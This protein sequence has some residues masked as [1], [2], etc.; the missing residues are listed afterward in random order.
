M[1]DHTHIHTQSTAHHM[2]LFFKIKNQRSS[3]SVSGPIYKG[4]IL[5][6]QPDRL[7]Y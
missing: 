4:F 5:L 2:L 7:V 6:W 3:Q 1:K